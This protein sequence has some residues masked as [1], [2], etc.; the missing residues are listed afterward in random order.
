MVIFDEAIADITQIHWDQLHA[1]MANPRIKITSGK[2]TGIDVMK[3][4]IKEFRKLKYNS[5]PM[6]FLEIQMETELF[7]EN[8]LGYTVLGQ[9]AVLW[10]SKYKDSERLGMG[11]IDRLLGEFEK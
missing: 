8:W 5:V 3:R 9:F 2:F 4:Y 7:R 6:K 1:T 11:I 10:K